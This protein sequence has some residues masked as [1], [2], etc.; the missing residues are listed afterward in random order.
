MA[1]A[2]NAS[3]F[4][5]HPP[6]LTTRFLAALDALGPFEPAAHLVIALSGGAD[7]MALALLAAEWAQL[8]GGQLTT[9]TVDH[10]LRP[11]S[12]T[13]AE[14]VASLMAARHIP[15]HILTPTHAEHSNNLQ[16]NAR[17]WRY[18]A[19]AEWCRTHHV[20]HCLVA[21]HAGDQRE[22]V[23]LHHARGDTADGPSGMATVRNYQGIRFLRPLLG[24]E[25]AELVQHLE[26]QGAAWVEDPSNRNTQFARVRMRETL[27]G[28]AALTADL[29]TRAAEESEARSARDA[30][31]AQA[32]MQCVTFSPA[33][34]AVL[35]LAAWKRLDKLLA[36]QMLAD[37]LTTISGATQRPRKADTDRL[38]DALRAPSLSRRTLHGCEIDSIKGVLRIAREASRVAA[39][40]TLSGT[41]RL[42]W[43]ARF[44]VQYDV[45]A[46][47]PLTLRALDNHR[48]SGLP[49]ATPSLWHLDARVF[50][51]HITAI[52]HDLPAGARVSIGF[53]P[54][55][56]LA[57][58]P[59]WWL[60]KN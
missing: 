41:G 15:H 17:A 22:T 33:G 9:L 43:D 13:E 36:S 56:P 28:D 6:S 24:F 12:R 7:S 35:D 1:P 25:K 10:G 19:L 49:A 48:R 47:H 58:A 32:A 2:V 4:S 46:S 39:P 50:V 30:Q 23:A 8:R 16:E 37:V 45:P 26:A 29:T 27:Q 60:N 55:K 3:A 14:H 20:L 11:E 5:A 51:P 54:A 57:A 40:V 42:L 18:D 34:Y 21:H 44:M 31:L 53:A 59:F 52:A 38:C